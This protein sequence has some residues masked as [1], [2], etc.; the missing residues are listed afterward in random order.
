MTASRRLAALPLMLIGLAALV[1]ALV[2]IPWVVH[3]QSQEVTPTAGYVYAV[4]AV[5]EHGDSRRSGSA[6][7]DSYLVRIL[8]A[9]WGCNGRGESANGGTT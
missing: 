8:S 3:A 4:G 9:R 7:A 2:L 1:A 6:K 5:N